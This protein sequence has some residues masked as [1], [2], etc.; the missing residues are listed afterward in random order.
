MNL[1]NCFQHAEK[2]Q[3]VFSGKTLVNL[4]TFLSAEFEKIFREFYDQR[5]SKR[6]T[7][8]TR[9][10]RIASFPIPA[11]ASYHPQ[12]ITFSAKQARHRSFV[13]TKRLFYTRGVT[14]PRGLI[15]QSG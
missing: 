5:G 9:S 14:F 10:S 11:R 13:P 1:K 2:K 15:A 12:P 6:I 8:L 4:E 3:F 7:G